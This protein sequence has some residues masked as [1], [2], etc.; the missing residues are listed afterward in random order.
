LQQ[1]SL[2][3]L[4]KRFGDTIQALLKLTAHEAGVDGYGLYEFDQAKS[5]LS[6]LYAHG[7]RAPASKVGDQFAAVL[8]F[9]L[10]GALGLAGIL[11]FGFLTTLPEEEDRLDI[12]RRS[13]DA[14]QT[15]LEFSRRTGACIQVLARTVEIETQIAELKIAGRARDLLGRSAEKQDAARTLASHVERV[16]AA[17]GLREDLESQL[18]GYASLLDER[19]LVAKAKFLLQQTTGCTEEQ[20]YLIL[21]NAS[22]RSRRQM[23]EVA[24]D[25]L[26]RGARSLERLSA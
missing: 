22:R 25:L 6:L 9:P 21:R 7:L 14:I 5:H 12:L 15:I 3:V 11:D 20:A 23:Q 8:S 17:P 1:Y 16:L 4:D 13:A 10:R 26:E 18:D 19:E 24:R 2:V